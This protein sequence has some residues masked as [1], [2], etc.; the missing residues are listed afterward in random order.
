MTVSTALK[1]QRV[2]IFMQAE[3]VYTSAAKTTDL[4]MGRQDEGIRLFDGQVVENDAPG[5]GRSDQE[6]IEPFV[7]VSGQTACR[8]TL[9]LDDPAA[10]GAQLAF[11]A[12]ERQDNQSTLRF[13]INGQPVLRPPSRQAAPQANQY[14]GLMVGQ[15][16]W[17]RWYYVD[18]PP[19]TLRLGENVIEVAAVEGLAGWQLMVADYRDFYK[20]MDDPVTLPYASRHS[21]DGGQTSKAE[22]GEYV[23]RLVLDRFRSNGELVSKVIDAAGEA[24]DAVKSERSLQRITLDWDADIPEGT[25]LAWALR[26][27][28]RP[29]WDTDHWSGWQVYDGQP[30]TVRG[31]YL[32]WKVDFSVADGLQ[33]PVLKSV[34][35]NADFQQGERFTGRLVSTKNAQILRPSIPMPYED[36]RAQILRDCASNANWT[37]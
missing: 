5:S 6:H 4:W 35:I 3:E 18:I 23:L 28:S 25:Q 11:I 30:A 12:K 7:E 20:G 8:K 26:T 9:H 29:V 36:Y 13:T 19:E 34:Q 15:W 33:S 14:W 10:L 22:R 1:E 32:Q 37:R 2:T 16:S 31:R 27:G 24:E 21:I 17:S